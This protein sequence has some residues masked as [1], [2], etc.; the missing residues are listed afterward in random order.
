M[1]EQV[2]MKIYLGMPTNLVDIMGYQR[3]LNFFNMYVVGWYTLTECH[4]HFSGIT[5][6]GLCL[7]LIS[8]EF[9]GPTPKEIVGIVKMYNREFELKESFLTTTP[10]HTTTIR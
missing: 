3:A 5:G 4:G 8:D 1:T 9:N 7:E 10:I 2:L 6:G